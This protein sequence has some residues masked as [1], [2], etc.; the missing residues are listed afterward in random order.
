MKE[1][2][3]YLKEYLDYLEIEKNRSPKTVENYR[4]YLSEFINQEKISSLE[5][6]DQDKIRHFRIWLARRQGKEEG[7]LKKKHPKLLH[8]CLKK[9]SQV[10]N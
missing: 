3:K 5:E 8:H 7:F 10:F 1:I 4:R 9:F 2:Q 6:I